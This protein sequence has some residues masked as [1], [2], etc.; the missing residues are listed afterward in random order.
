MRSVRFFAALLAVSVVFAAAAWAEPTEVGTTAATNTDTRGTPPRMAARSLFIGTNVFFEE[1]IETSKSGQAQLLFLD[2][3]ALTIASNSDVVL[4]KFIYDPKTSKGELALSIG[5]GVFR[6]VGGRISKTSVVTIKT[7]TATLGIRGGIV[8]IKVE[9]GTGATRATF[10]FG[11]EMT[12]T[13]DSGVTRR[14]TR[15]G[16]GIDVASLVAPPSWPFKV[17]GAKMAFY[18]TELEGRTGQTAGSDDPP[19]DEKVADSGINQV[20][21]SNDPESIVGEE[22]AA[23]GD[24][25]PT[26]PASLACPPIPNFEKY[27]NFSLNLGDGGNGGGKGS[28]PTKTVPKPK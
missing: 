20:G 13:N 7:P 26:C 15:P 19:T 16:F 24:D 28:G 6:F 11:K 5:A 3:S 23:T 10:V 25:D 21:S 12:V 14:V 22:T 1:R 27:T 8:I 4:D 2:E 18:L 17:S 9:P